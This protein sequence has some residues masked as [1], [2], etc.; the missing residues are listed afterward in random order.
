[1][2]ARSPFQL[3]R[4]IIAGATLRERL[5]A[6]AGALIGMGLASLVT[7]LVVGG[8]LSLPFIVGPIAASAVLVFVVPTSPLAQPWPVLGGN[9][10]GGLAGVALAQ[11]FG[12][13]GW[14][15]PVIAAMA[16]PVGIVA[17][18]L[19][20]C[21]HP[22]G[23]AM[24]LLMAL[25]MKDAAPM[26][27]WRSLAPALLNIGVLLACGMVFHRLM[28]RRYP[29][30]PEAAPPGVHGSK[31]PPAAMRNVV[32]A[33]DIDAALA[34]LD[35]SYDIDRDDLLR[36]VRQAELAAIA[37]SS[38]D[39]RCASI[40]SRDIFSVTP[41]MPVSAAR[42]LLLAHNIRMLP[43]LDRRKHIVGSIGLREIATLYAAREGAAPVAGAAAD[44]PV[45]DVMTA[46]AIARPDTPVAELLP[47]LTDGRG[48]AA[49][50]VDADEHAIGLV[51][52]TDLL[53]AM[54]RA[55]SHNN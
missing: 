50:I 33:A 29:H 25:T 17:M 27:V 55:V 11:L 6:C 18:S 16:V 47:I 35:A 40:M 37:R 1:M 15:G 19:C 7:R 43:V 42:E 46:A 23:G 41:D 5:L 3:F 26:D 54:A 24:A 49:V 34:S 31:D 52:Q 45:G 10:V 30:Q 13:L 2:P 20:R 44:T 8:D 36:L 4:P 53:W 14:S 51:T 22:P 38:P 9:L 21:L 39:I 12:Q 48:H 32:D 28:G